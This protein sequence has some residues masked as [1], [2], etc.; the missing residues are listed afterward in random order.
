MIDAFHDDVEIFHV[1]ENRRKIGAAFKNLFDSHFHQ[2]RF[3]VDCRR[4]WKFW[5]RQSFF[6]SLEFISFSKNKDKKADTVQE[7]PNKR[8]KKQPEKTEKSEKTETT[9]KKDTKPEKV[10]SASLL[11]QLIAD[12]GADGGGDDGEKDKGD[13]NK[14]KK[15]AKK[16]KSKKDDKWTARPSQ[17]NGKTFSREW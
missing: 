10:D 1:S 15:R 17:V 6:S 5:N 14:G 4:N 3:Q 2:L 8:F 11:N 12:D 7:K 13:K 16:G 9:E